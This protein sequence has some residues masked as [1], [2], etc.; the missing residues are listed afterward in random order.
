MFVSPASREP[1]RG[2]EQ[3]GQTLV[4]FAL[5]IPF[6]MLLFMALVELALAFNAF[7]A[8]NRASQNGGHLAAIMTNQVGSDCLILQ[9]IEADVD[10][11]NKR[12]NIVNVV[13]ERTALAGNYSYQNQHYDRV[14]QM[15]CTLPNGSDIDVPYTLRPPT[16]D[17]PAYP[18][19]ERCPVLKGCPDLGR[20]T[21]DNIGVKV[22]YRHDWVT[23]LAVTLDILPGGRNGWVF[24]QR[25]IFRM[26]PTL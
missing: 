26:E 20:S 10:T 7:I 15:T 23:P 16:V 1:K 5:V 4:E 6:V 25:N 19:D 9:E 2:S 11:P 8:I 21:V 22:R 12:S 17:E 14:G 13:V 3:S 24:T 18:E